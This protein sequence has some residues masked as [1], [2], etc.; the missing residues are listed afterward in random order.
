MQKIDLSEFKLVTK[1]KSQRK[2]KCY[3]YSELP[4]LPLFHI[5]SFGQVRLAAHKNERQS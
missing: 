3:L 1:S 2:W 5:I 4:H